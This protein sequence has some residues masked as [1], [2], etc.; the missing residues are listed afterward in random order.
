M[1]SPRRVPLIL[2]RCALSELPFIRMLQTTAAAHYWCV[3]LHV[4]VLVT[5]LTVFKKESITTASK[6]AIGDYHLNA[7]DDPLT[8][9]PT[10]GQPA[11]FVILHDNPDVQSAVLSPCYSRT[12]IKDGKVVARR[13]GSVQHTISERA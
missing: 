5:Y 8:L 1:L 13:I 10:P 4:F 3:D 2:L 6:L 9:L 7:L 12:T 11:N